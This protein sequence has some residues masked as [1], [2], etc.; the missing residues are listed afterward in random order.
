MGLQSQKLA[1]P[2][3]CSETS[4]KI[5]SATKEAMAAADSITKIYACATMWHESPMEMMCMLKS[6]F[7]YQTLI[8]VKIY[9]LPLGGYT[10]SSS[11]FGGGIYTRGREV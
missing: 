1:P 4:S 3:V 10:N 11:D 8:T 9:V 5:S 7:R 6:I 2:S